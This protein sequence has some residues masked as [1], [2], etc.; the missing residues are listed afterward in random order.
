MHEATDV[1]L[2][3]TSLARV[4]FCAGTDHVV[5][6]GDGS[7]RCAT[8]RELD[9]TGVPIDACLHEKNKTLFVK[10][11]GVLAVA[12]VCEPTPLRMRPPFN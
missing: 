4:N 9:G 1:V 2:W 7:F 8:C 12:P 3:G 11:C 6:A 10:S 5:V